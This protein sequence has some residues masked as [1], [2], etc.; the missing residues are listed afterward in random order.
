MDAGTAVEQ[1]GSKE[2]RTMQTYKN[3]KIVTNYA[4]FCSA[5]MLT[6]KIIPQITEKHSEVSGCANSCD[7]FV[8]IRS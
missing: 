1:G 5:T 7:I 6:S 2:L 8:S 4:F 3:P